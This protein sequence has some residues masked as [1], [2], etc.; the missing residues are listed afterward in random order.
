LFLR[1]I[2]TIGKSDI[3]AIMCTLFCVSLFVLGLSIPT[4]YYGFEDENSTCQEGTRGGLDLSDWVK[5]AGLSSIIITAWVWIMAALAAFTE[6][7]VFIGA[8]I[9]VLVADIFLWIMW[10]IW[11]VV[12]LAT[13]ENNNCVAQGKG[14]AV[15]AIIN[16]VMG[17]L[18]F[19]YITM[20]SGAKD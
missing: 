10:W 4:V 19:A 8:A 7:E 1:N 3:A 12:I 2:V 6:K 18:R 14:M 16:L 20:L 17:E 5:G 11:G 15:M 9:G 13:N